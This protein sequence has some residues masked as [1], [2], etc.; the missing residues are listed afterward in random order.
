MKKLLLT[1]ILMALLLSVSACGENIGTSETSQTTASVQ[2]T[3]QSV[4]TSQTSQTTQTTSTTAAPECKHVY[5]E[6]ETIR[7]ALCNQKGE[8]IRYCT[9]CGEKDVFISN[10]AAHNYVSEIIPPTKAE[11][12]YTKFTCS[13]CGESYTKDP[14]PALGSQGLA[15]TPLDDKSYD[16]PYCAITGM[17]TCTDTDIVIPSY[18]DGY[19][20]LAIYTEAFK[21]QTQITSITIPDTVTSFHHRAFQGCT[22]LTEFTFP[23]RTM[24]A[25]KNLF[26]GCDNL[27]TV[28]FCFSY[29]AANIDEKLLS[30]ANAVK[31]VSFD[32]RYVYRDICKQNSTI[33]TVI[34]KSGV[35]EIEAHA[36]YD[37]PNL[38][39]VIFEDAEKGWLTVKSSAFENCKSLVS[40]TFSSAISVID[41]TAFWGCSSLSS[42][43]L[44]K[45]AFAMPASLFVYCPLESVYYMGTEADWESIAVIEGNPTIAAAKRYYYSE[46]VPEKEGNFWH[47]VDGT[48]TIWE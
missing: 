33:E 37:C 12:G 42:V 30:G 2:T 23:K 11:D 38:K 3:Q 46:T 36:F 7:E 20:V 44:N 40:V 47:Y 31:T 45:T 25:G 34:I 13:V 14:V 18:I 8:K 41:N 29:Y 10:L 19:E 32:S 16:K 17:G 6:W 48:P 15:F 27:E 43:V 21:D 24:V 26:Q 35:R 22:G 1:S 9:K 5:G 28:N 4:Q 39:N